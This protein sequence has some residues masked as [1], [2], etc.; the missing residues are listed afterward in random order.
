MSEDVLLMSDPD[1]SVR[2][3]EESVTKFAEVPRF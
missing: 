2:S 1:F 3:I